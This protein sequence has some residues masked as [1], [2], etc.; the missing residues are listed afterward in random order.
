M[1]NSRENGLPALINYLFPFKLKLT[2]AKIAPGKT[3]TSNN[4]LSIGTIF[5]NPTF[6]CILNV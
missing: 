2:E 3:L 1:Q 4:S 5:R 6:V